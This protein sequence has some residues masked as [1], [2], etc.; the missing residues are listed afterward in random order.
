LARTRSFPTTSDPKVEESD[1]NDK[2]AR[3]LA[4]AQSLFL[5]YG[6]KRT[7]VDDV[8]RESGIAKGTVYLY[9]DSKDAL[10]K[11]IAERICADRLG[12][13]QA[14]LS[15]DGPLTQRLVSFLDVFA[16]EMHRLIAESPHVAELTE[17]KHEYGVTTFGTNGAQMKELLR[18]ALR[19][20]GI[21]RKGADDMFLAAAFGAVETG[22]LAEKPYRARLTALVDTLVLGLSHE[23]RR[24]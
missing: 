14:A 24:R 4:T 20:E 17:A 19:K 6:V 2:R 12:R 15:V 1:S 8:A 21:I 5:R 3:I 11:A 9:F 7:S 23:A 16:G 10:F 13:A 22:D 18:A